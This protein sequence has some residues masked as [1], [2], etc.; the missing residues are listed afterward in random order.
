MD[1]HD[2][3][4]AFKCT[5]NDGGSAGFVGFDGT[6]S[7][8]NIRRNVV[9]KPR[10]WCSSEDNRCSRFHDDDF[11]GRRPIHPC[12]ESQIFSMH[13]FQGYIARETDRYLNVFWNAA[14]T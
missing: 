12:Y 6:C 8:E 4:V 10:V 2:G 14:E 3:N 11:R 5:Y 7:N 13:S 1:G 9:E